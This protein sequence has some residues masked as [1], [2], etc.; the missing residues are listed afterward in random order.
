ME[1]AEVGPGKEEKNDEEPLTL[2]TIILAGMERGLTMADIRKMQ[3][4]TVVD[5]VI[6]YNN[7]QKKAEERAEHASK[8]KHYRRASQ[9]EIDA[10]L[11]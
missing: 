5:F 1:K 7:R 11:G 3:L 2:E 4:G 8:V 9:A 10:F 6:E